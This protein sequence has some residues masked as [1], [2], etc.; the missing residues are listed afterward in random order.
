MNYRKQFNKILS[1]KNDNSAIV[2]FALIGGIAIGAALSVLF[3]PKKGTE[4]REEITE[5]GRRLCGTLMELADG[6]KTK[7]SHE[8]NPLDDSYDDDEPIADGNTPAKKPKSDIGEF[9]QQAH[10]NSNE[11]QS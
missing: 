9:I 5:G 10:Q 8:K 2:G 6:L 7:L 1:G 11:A 3:A 4:L